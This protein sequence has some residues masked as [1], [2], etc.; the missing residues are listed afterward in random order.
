LSDAIVAPGW[1]SKP[2]RGNPDPMLI[3]NS[4]TITAQVFGYTVTNRA[5]CR[6]KMYH[7]VESDGVKIP[8]TAAEFR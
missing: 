3:V 7:R 2:I 8:T 5:Q 6:I 1:T 4:T